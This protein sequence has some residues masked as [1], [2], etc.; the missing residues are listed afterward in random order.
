MLSRDNYFGI[1][2]ELL[3]RL[4]HLSNRATGK[5]SILDAK[6]SISETEATSHHGNRT[7]NKTVE[8]LMNQVIYSHFR[9]LFCVFCFHLVIAVH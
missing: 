6:A 4:F 7:K 5:T 3:Q 8:E 1:L 9:F 2:I